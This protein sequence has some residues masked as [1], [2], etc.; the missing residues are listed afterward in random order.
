MIFAERLAEERRLAALRLLS[1]MSGGNANESV[2]QIGLDHYGLTTS[3]ALV[4]AD[5]AMLAEHLLIRLEKLPTATGELWVAHLTAEGD[6]VA[7]GRTVHPGV[8]RRGPG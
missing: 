4:R 8:K 5:M 2:I 1:E 7:A 6:D 3:R